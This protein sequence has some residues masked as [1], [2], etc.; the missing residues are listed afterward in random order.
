MARLDIIK[1]PVT[2]NQYSRDLDVQGSTYTAYNAPT[3]VSSVSS[4]INTPT[5]NTSNRTLDNGFDDISSKLN[6]TLSTS[7]ADL[8]DF[9][10]TEKSILEKFADRKSLA[11][12][13]GEAERKLIGNESTDTINSQLE[14]NAR[15]LINFNEGGSGFAKQK[16]AMEFIVD[17]GQKRVRELEK[18]RD[19]LL[20]N[21]KVQEASRLD[22][23]I[24]T[25]Q[26]SITSARTNYINSVLNIGK[27]LR[28]IANFETPEQ[29]Q[30][31]KL[32]LSR[33]EQD[34]AFQIS[35]KQSV[36]QL[37]A[38]APDANIL[39][40]DDYFTAI[41]KYRGSSTYKRNETLGE[42]EIKQANA[43]IQQS[44]ASADASRASAAKSRMVEKETAGGTSLYS[45]ERAFR[46]NQS[47]DEL[48]GRVDNTTV[49]LGSFGARIP[50][51]PAANFAA[52]LKQLKAAIAFTELNAMREASKTGGAL[53]S[54]SEKELALL[55]SSLGAL[56]TVQSPENFK[57][58]LIKIKESIDRF[59]KATEQ[60]SGV[61]NSAMGLPTTSVYTENTATPTTSPSGFLPTGNLFSKIFNK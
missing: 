18:A 51:T 31:R 14:N 25:E 40:T 45:Q 5:P 12:A 38:T 22:N 49:G 23:L 58:N 41:Q 19:N 11:K 32:E 6:D 8:G 61:N 2:G 54:I 3:N 28:D 7:L 56:D 27:E 59:Q 57:R 13:G 50:G 46:V 44:L 17:T 36:Q 60:Y 52:D 55:E 1:D 15:S 29:A 16:V 10:S 34:I 47:V 33:G 43:S 9:K 42:L 20:L 37:A 4:S 39:P 30:Q 24:A 48:M 21:S 35:T 26:E 53:G